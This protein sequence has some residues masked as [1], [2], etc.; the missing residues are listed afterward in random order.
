M[1]K[2][3]LLLITMLVVPHFALTQD[4]RGKGR[5]YGNVYDENGKPIEGVKVKLYFPRTKSGF[6]VVTDS[7]GKWVAA[8]IR[9]GNW[10]MDFEKAGFIPKKISV[11][12]KEL[13]RNLPVDITLIALQQAE[14][15]VLLDELEETLRQGN[16]LS[17][18]EKYQEAIGFFEIIL[19]KSPDAYIVNMNIGNSYFELKNFDKAEEYYLKVLEK[20]PD[21]IHA[22][23]AIS[24]CYVNRGNNNKAQEWYD[25]LEF[26]KIDD[27]AVLYN[28]GTNYYNI[29]K[30]QEAMKYYRKSVEI[31]KD[32]LDGYYQLGLTLLNLQHNAEAIAVFGNYLKIDPD[33]ERAVQVKTFIEFIKK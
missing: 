4:Y 24:S 8:W 17:G 1:K 14:K 9:G 32:F 31:Q 2:V 30:F 21:N 29:S 3:I 12:L 11:E 15:I 25:K 27:P 33:S 5:V 18:E 19:E 22:I 7:K 26:D 16:K 10:D 6:E 23:M 20:E 13:G 28:I